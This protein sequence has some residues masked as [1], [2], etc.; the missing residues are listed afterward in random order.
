MSAVGLVV[1]QPAEAALEL[2]ALRSANESLNRRLRLAE[3]LMGKA[4]PARV[5]V[6]RQEPESG[7][8]LQVDQVHEFV[9]VENDLGDVVIADEGAVRLMCAQLGLELKS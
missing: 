3:A 7:I 1:F 9:R 8:Q 4:R 2:S 5:V 6:V